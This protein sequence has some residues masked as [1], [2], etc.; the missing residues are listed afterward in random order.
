MRCIYNTIVDIETKLLK[1]K[2]AMTGAFDHDLNEDDHVENDET[3]EPY[4]LWKKRTTY[5][6]E[7]LDTFIKALDL[8]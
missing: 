2:E 1:Q 5:D 7:Q 4:V 6:I 8:E 3:F